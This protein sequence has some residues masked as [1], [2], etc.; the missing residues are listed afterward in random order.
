[1]SL[2]LSKFYRNLRHFDARFYHSVF[3]KPVRCFMMKM[4]D[5]VSIPKDLDVSDTYCHGSNES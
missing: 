2:S 1:M 4:D 3:C 5:W